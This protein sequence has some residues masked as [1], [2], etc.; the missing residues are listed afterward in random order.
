MDDT[1]VTWPHGPEKLMGFLEKL[2]SIHH[3]IQL[4]ME[5]EIHTHHP[6]LD[7]DVYRKLVVI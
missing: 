1:F 6:S 2:K 7:I 3:N 5:M 4:T